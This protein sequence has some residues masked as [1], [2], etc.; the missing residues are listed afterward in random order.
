MPTNLS[1]N[2][3]TVAVLKET[4]RKLDED[5]EKTPE[6]IELRKIL[7]KRITEINKDIRTE[8]ARRDSA[9]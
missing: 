6:M 2:L 8:T 4:L 9:K 3:K 1:R 7:A 5:R